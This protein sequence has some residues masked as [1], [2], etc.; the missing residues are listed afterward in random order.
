LD[1]VRERSR[2]PRERVDLAGKLT[3]ARVGRAE[4]VAP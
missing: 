3:A 2:E 4:L 1:P